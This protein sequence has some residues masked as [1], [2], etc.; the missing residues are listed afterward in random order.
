MISPLL[1]EELTKLIVALIIG[2]IIGAEREYKSKAAGFRTV[3][4]ITVGS[5]LFT[6]VSNAIGDDGRVASNIVTGIGFLGAGSIFREGTTVKGI[7][8]ATTIWISAAIGMAIGMG[9]Y[10]F[11]FIALT[12]VMLVLLSFSW[13][14]Q[15][16]D[17]TNK[18]ETYTITLKNNQQTNK[19]TLKQIIKKY[20]LKVSTKKQAKNNDYQT[21]VFSVQGS[22]LNHS[23]LIESLYETDFIVSFEV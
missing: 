2:A 13:I 18:I 21:F 7:T 23:K 20:N 10:E 8:T 3:I 9:K 1:Y 22:S 5:T 4:L 17:K 11:A 16:I 6:I 15:M 19:E 14:Q 12:I